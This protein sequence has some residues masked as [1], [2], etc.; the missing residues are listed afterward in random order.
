MRFIGVV[1]VSASLAMATG[2]A[3]APV[4]TWLADDAQFA[5]GE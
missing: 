5:L 3:R 4:R 1:A 2:A